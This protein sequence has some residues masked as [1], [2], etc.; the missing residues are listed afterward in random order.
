MKVEK[1]MMSRSG[2]G[3]SPALRKSVEGKI[4]K[5][6]KVVITKKDF[7]QADS[8]LKEDR[9]R[10]RVEL[11]EQQR[12]DEQ[13]RLYKN[14][15][16]AVRQQVRDLK[17]Q[18]AER[19]Y[20]INDL[21]NDYKHRLA[22][23]RRQLVDVEEERGG[24]EEYIEDLE[25]ELFRLR[26]HLHDLDGEAEYILDLERDLLIEKERNIEKDKIISDLRQKNLVQY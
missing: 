4:L 8:V 14:Q 2:R 18:A 12:F 11:E 24:Q 3:R 19:E 25:K 21:E 15:L 26:K 17:E 1:R 7:L 5:E 23:A 20:Y 10:R 13:R 22:S 6:L 9:I 16:C